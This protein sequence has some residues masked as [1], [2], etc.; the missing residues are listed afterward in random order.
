MRGAIYHLSDHQQF[1]S[2]EAADIICDIVS[3]DA[4]RGDTIRF[5]NFVHTHI[6][7]RVSYDV[8]DITSFA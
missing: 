7:K 1:C 3:V 6:E 4:T 5:M 2:Y 8:D